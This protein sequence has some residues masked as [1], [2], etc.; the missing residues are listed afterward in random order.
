MPK[1]KIIIITVLVVLVILS[2]C[3]QM[4]FLMGLN[5]TLKA[6]VIPQAKKCLGVNVDIGSSSLDLIGRSLKISDV[7]IGNP[8]GFSGTNILSLNDFR[9]EWSTIPLYIGIIRIRTIK[10]DKLVVAVEINRDGLS[11]IQAIR[12][13]LTKSAPPPAVPAEPKKTEKKEE[14]AAEPVRLPNI[15]VKKASVNAL[16]EFADYKISTNA[17]RIAFD[18]SLRLKNLATFGNTNPEKWGTFELNANLKD[19]PESYVTRIK[20]KVA[21]IT[22]PEKPGFD[23]EGCIK[24]IDFSALKEYVAQMGITGDSAELSLKIKCRDGKFDNDVSLITLKI[25]NPK[26]IDKHGKIRSTSLPQELVVPVAIGGTIQKPD[27]QW[28]IAL[29]NVI[30]DL[31]SKGINS[32]LDQLFQENQKSEA[33]PAAS[34]ETSRRRQGK[35]TSRNQNTAR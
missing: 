2:A 35:K 11:N 13:N 12:N 27:V 16:A 7:K 21:P 9:S 17:F 22:D 26:L 20:G 3:S 23:A 19:K 31:T 32:L 29:L 1:K 14:K 15:I 8:A 10:A 30:S 6:T 28:A 24:S 34:R 25:T 33:N 4:F 18:I 5:K